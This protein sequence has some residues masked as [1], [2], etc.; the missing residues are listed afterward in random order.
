MASASVEVDFAR[1]ARSEGG[2]WDSSERLS[3]MHYDN[4]AWDTR[5]FFFVALR[6]FFLGMGIGNGSCWSCSR[7]TTRNGHSHLQ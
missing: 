2:Y 1:S 3:E 4:G 6:G 5:F 7:C